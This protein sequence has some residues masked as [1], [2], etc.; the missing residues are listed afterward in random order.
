MIATS[1]ADSELYAIVR[2]STEALGLLTLLKGVGMAVVDSRVNVD[3]S[4]SRSIVEREGLGNFRHIEVGLLWT[5][6]Q[7]LRK[8]LPLSQI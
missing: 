1:S 7:Q 8:R 6:E 3:A 5:Q 2:A 4:A